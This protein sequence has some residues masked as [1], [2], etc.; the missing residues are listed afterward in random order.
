VARFAFILISVLVGAAAALA[1]LHFELLP[2]YRL[3]AP[4]STL[5]EVGVRE[6]E[7]ERTPGEPTRRVVAL[8]RLQPA[9]GIVE[10]GGVPGDKIEKLNVV[11]GQKVR[12]QDELIVFESRTLRRLE[13][14][15]AAAQL[16]EAE[17]RLKAEQMHAD[18]LVRSAQ[19]AV[20]GLGLD[21]LDQKAQEAKIRALA[22]GAELAKRNLERLSGIDKSITS[23]QQL[24]QS[25]LQ[26]DQA[27]AELTA[28]QEML[29]KLIAGRELRRREAVA[30]QDQAIAG[31]AKVDAVV[32]LESARR[33]LALADERV[34]LATLT[35][36]LD[37]TILEVPAD[38]GD[39][40]GPTPLV[41]MADVSQMVAVAEVYETQIAAVRVGQKCTLTAEALS[42]P[43]TGTV[44]RIGS[45]VGPNRL[46]SLDPRRSTDDRVVEV[47][48][49]IHE[50]EQAAERSNLQ[51][52]ATI[53]TDARP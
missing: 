28:A 23:A 46:V 26:Q 30:A 40:V 17:S 37:G 31:R 43:L 25:R 10:L 41:R 34:R 33:A 1:L 22:E 27:Q 18:T 13:R 52:T 4:T 3:V 45:V 20:D 35:A 38:E 24:E 14:E 9:A 19:V 2:G 39:A 36:P 51:V 53:E 5:P 47:R 29:K 48:I 15:A 44:E 42:S 21:E 12:R 6:S 49:R 16:A 32:P 8:A 50:A 7:P 11:A